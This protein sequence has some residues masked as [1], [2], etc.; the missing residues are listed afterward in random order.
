[1]KKTYYTLIPLFLVIVISSI[2]LLLAKKNIHQ[3]VTSPKAFTEPSNDEEKMTIS[4]GGSDIKINNLYKN[5][6]SIL[7]H[8]GVLF[9]QTSDF[10][11][12]FYSSDQGFIV[13][14]LNPDL[15]KVREEAE[16]AFL[17]TLGISK[18]QACL[19][20]ISLGTTADINLE[21]AGQNYGLSFCPNG[22]PLPSK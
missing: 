12:L 4:A 16:K 17:D 7:N 6:V 22:K 9:Q 8:S 10:E 14:L 2:Y 5:P 13:S 3:N 15:K 20:K 19:L 21:A 1:M 18:E 11:M